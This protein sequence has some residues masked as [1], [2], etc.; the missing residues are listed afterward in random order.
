M[1]GYFLI[2]SLSDAIIE[3]YLL[4]LPAHG[5]LSIKF[6]NKYIN[7]FKQELK[8]MMIPALQSDKN[9]FFHNCVGVSA[10]K[11]YLQYKRVHVVMSEEF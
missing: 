11:L 4:M 6:K 9:I 1:L 7:S 5:Y 3:I 8:H 2:W 10:E